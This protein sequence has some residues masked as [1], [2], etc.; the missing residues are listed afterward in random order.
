MTDKER[1]W[2]AKNNRQA[3]L[4][5]LRKNYLQETAEIS[6]EYNLHPKDDYEKIDELYLGEYDLTDEE[7]EYV[8]NRN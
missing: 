8:I 4:D 1:E 7:Y 2:C 6:Y 5:D 3:L